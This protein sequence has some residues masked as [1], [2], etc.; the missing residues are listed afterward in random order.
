MFYNR[1]GDIWSIWPLNFFL[2]LVILV[3]IPGNGKQ[4]QVEIF[5]TRG[6]WGGTYCHRNKYSKMI[7]RVIHS[8]HTRRNTTQKVNICVT[9][10]NVPKVQNK[11]WFFFHEQGVPKSVLVKTGTFQYIEYILNILK[12]DL[13]RCYYKW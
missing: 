9:T 7:R 10:K 3:H 8:H 11:P 1:G 6:C 4:D 13:N 12:L 5:C 2:V